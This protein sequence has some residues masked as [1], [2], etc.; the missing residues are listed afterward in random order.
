MPLVTPTLQPL[1]VAAVVR[2]AFL[3]G[4]RIALETNGC[5]TTS[6]GRVV[7]VNERAAVRMSSDEQRRFL[8]S[9]RK[10]VLASSGRDGSIQLVVMH[11]GFLDDGL[12]FLTKGSSQ[13]VRNFRRDPRA[14]IIVH[15]NERYNELQGL[16]LSGRIEIIDDVD[17]VMEV[18]RTMQLRYDEVKDPAKLERA[19]HNRVVLKFAT[20]RAISWDHT[21]IGAPPWSEE[22]T[23]RRRQ[24]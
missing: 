22:A 5:G 3:R 23:A 9:G 4:R 21:K 1:A 6:G 12:A 19:M 2:L 8:E 14:S 24:G 17:R 10:L 7:G 15:A 20:K 16:C 11:Y 18:A 13:K